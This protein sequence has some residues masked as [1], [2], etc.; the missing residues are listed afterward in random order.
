MVVGYNRDHGQSMQVVWAS[1]SGP[2]VP[3]TV[4]GRPCANQKSMMGYIA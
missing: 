1:A 3:G 4:V 2:F